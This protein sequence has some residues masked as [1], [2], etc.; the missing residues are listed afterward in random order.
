MRFS[1]LPPSCQLLGARVR[2]LIWERNR[3]LVLCDSGALYRVDV[4]DSPVETLSKRAVVTQL[5]AFHAGGVV[6]LALL[7]MVEGAHQAVTAGLD[8]SLRVWNYR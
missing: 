6:G 4:G 3:W 8:G 5:S 1:D 7:P 2:S